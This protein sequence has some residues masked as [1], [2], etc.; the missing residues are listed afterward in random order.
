MGDE[1]RRERSE[2]KGIGCEW[3][4]HRCAMF[5]VWTACRCCASEVAPSC[6]TVQESPWRCAAVAGGEASGAAGLGMG[7]APPLVSLGA[8]R[9]STTTWWCLTRQGRDVI[10]QTY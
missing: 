4:T 8:S 9:L 3:A 6:A 5:I 7:T 1:R 2:Y 10:T